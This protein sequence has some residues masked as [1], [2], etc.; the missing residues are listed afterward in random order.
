MHWGLLVAALFLLHQ[1]GLLRQGQVL[2][3]GLV[4][5]SGLKDAGKSGFGDFGDTEP[6]FLL[7]DASGRQVRF[8][9]FAGKT[10]F[11]NFWASWCP[12][13]LAEMPSI[14]ALHNRLKT[15]NNVVFLMVSLDRDREKAKNLMKKKNYALPLYFP[16]TPLPQGF[17]TGSIPA[18]FVVDRQGKV[19]YRKE[20]IAN[21]ASESFAQALIKGPET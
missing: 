3:Q 13:C 12:P 10:V 16:A 8:G 9:D 1:T 4:L 15:D 17:E 5:K 6:G 21:Y 19:V 11:V 18:T 2:I 7:E 14:E 20:G